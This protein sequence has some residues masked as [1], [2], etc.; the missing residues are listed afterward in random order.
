V[1]DESKEMGLDRQVVTDQQLGC[2]SFLDNHTHGFD[3]VARL[4][5]V[6]ALRV[7]EPKHK[8]MQPC[9]IS[10]ADGVCVCACVCVCVWGGGGRSVW[11]TV[12]LKRDLPDSEQRTSVCEA[13]YAWRRAH[14]RKTAWTS[15]MGGPTSRSCLS[16]SGDRALA[17]QSS[18]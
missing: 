4:V 15:K 5:L 2:L 17:L 11:A 1:G 13:S 8:K 18:S 9:A 6:A 3:P 14:L 16:S 10:L 12:R 7:K